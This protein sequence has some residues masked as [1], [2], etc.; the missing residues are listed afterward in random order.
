M[1]AFLEAPTFFMQ[2]DAGGGR[3][4]DGAAAGTDAAAQRPGRGM[5]AIEGVDALRR[6]VAQEKRAPASPKKGRK[7]VAGQTEMLLPIAGKKGKEA[8]PVAK[9][10]TR[11]KK[12]G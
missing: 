12:A 4:Q 2:D 10:T 11:Q 6:S 1:L 7:R 5:R 8:K 9:P 3:R